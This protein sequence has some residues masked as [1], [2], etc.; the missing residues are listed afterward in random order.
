[1]E[2][3]EHATKRVKDM[4]LVYPKLKNDVE[5]DPELRSDATK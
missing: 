5:L 4:R 3:K 2:Q 1:M